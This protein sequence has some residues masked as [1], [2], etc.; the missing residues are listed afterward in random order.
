MPG[1]DQTTQL[2]W[3]I[4]ETKKVAKYT[5]QYA[6]ENDEEFTDVEVVVPTEG[7]V[8]KHQY[9]HKN[10]I[11]GLNYYQLTV[12]YEDGTTKRL[13]IE[14]VAFAKEQAPLN[15]FP[16]PARDVLNL[17]LSNFMEM[18]LTYFV[19]DIKGSV[20][21][22]GIIQRA[23]ADQ[24]TID[25]SQYENGSYLLYLRLENGEERSKQFVIMK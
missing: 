2:E 9:Q 3:E 18:E 4:E 6:N 5:I 25:I 23:H 15:I 12:E 8:I 13:P 20:V 16:N 7:A 14:Q 10:T 22:E 17:D 11:K 1:D 21:K 19:V 24:E